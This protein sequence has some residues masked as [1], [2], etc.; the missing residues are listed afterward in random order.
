MV[1]AGPDGSLFSDGAAVGWSAPAAL[2]RL[3]PHNAFPPTDSEGGGGEEAPQQ[4]PPGLLDVSFDPRTNWLVLPNL[5]L[6]GG[7]HGRFKPGPDGRLHEHAW[8]L[9]FYNIRDN[10]R[11]RI[12]AWQRQQSIIGRVL[13]F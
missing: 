4:V 10:V 5:P 6:D 2:Q 13:N 11:V 7:V 1:A 9:F 8:A 12:A 3:R